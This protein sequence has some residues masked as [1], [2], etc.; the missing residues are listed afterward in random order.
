M[1][2]SIKQVREQFREWTDGQCRAYRAGAFSQ[3]RGRPAED[4]AGDHDHE[5]EEEE[6]DYTLFFYRGYA[7]AAGPDIAG[8]DW[9]D[10]IRDWRIVDRWW[11]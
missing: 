8:E 4:A 10:E 9:F 3:M 7:D 6:A 2:L 5:D 11:E 1:N